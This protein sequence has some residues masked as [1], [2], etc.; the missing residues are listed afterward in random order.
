[1]P[2]AAL[3]TE[4]PMNLSLNSA[5]TYVSAGQYFSMTLGI[6]IDYSTYEYIYPLGFFVDWGAYLGDVI[7]QYDHSVVKL[8][9]VSGINPHLLELWLNHTNDTDLLV[10]TTI[11]DSSSYVFNFEALKSGFTNLNILCNASGDLFWYG[12]VP[13]D[14]YFGWNFS[15]VTGANG[16]ITGNVNV[17]EPATM[18]LLAL[19]LIGLAGVPIPLISPP[20]SEGI[21]HAIPMDV[22]SL[23]RIMSPPL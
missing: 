3:A 8:L 23:I 11:L 13:E 10:G 12:Y 14:D 17:S 15:H 22:A 2:A 5:N 1:L 16:S 20:D 9:S 7:L 18:L 4:L 21:R 6:A 19:G